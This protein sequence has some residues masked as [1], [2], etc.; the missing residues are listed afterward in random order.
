MGR[1]IQDSI[2]AENINLTIE[3]FK[4]SSEGLDENI[5]VTKENIFAFM[6]SCRKLSIKR[7][8]PPT[9]SAKS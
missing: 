8:L 1:L 5:E 7:K 6:E 2:I 9:N 4:K 3:N